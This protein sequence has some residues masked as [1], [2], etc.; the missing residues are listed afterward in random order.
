MLL[1][2]N[3]VT[4][5]SWQIGDFVVPKKTS[6][7]CPS[8]ELLSSN[9]NEAV[10]R[11]VFESPTSGSLSAR[12][13]VSGSVL[14]EFVSKK[15][16]DGASVQTGSSFMEKPFS[17]E[18][19]RVPTSR[20]IH[21]SACHG[22]KLKASSA[23]HEDLQL[24]VYTETKSMDV[25]GETKSLTCMAVDENVRADLKRMTYLDP[26]AV[27]RIIKECSKTSTSLTGLFEA[28][29]PK[30][31]ME[32]L[33]RASRNIQQSRSD[34]NLAQAISALGKLALLVAEKA[35]PDEC[36][37]TVSDNE[38]KG[39][40]LQSQDMRTEDSTV[41]TSR[42]LFQRARAGM[43]EADS[44][45]ALQESSRANRL[46]SLQQRRRMLLSMMSRARRTEGAS[47]ADI[48]S[49][50]VRGLSPL[51]MNADTAAAF[52]FASSGD[53]SNFGEFDEDQDS[54]FPAMRLENS[55]PSD[56]APYLAGSNSECR[57][58]EETLLDTVLRGRTPGMLPSVEEICPVPFL[59]IR[60]IVNL[61]ILSNS[62]PWLKALLD[63]VM[64]KLPAKQA[65]KR[66]S[67]ILKSA[68]DEDRTPLL[69]VAM[70]LGCSG[71]I[72]KELIAF[73]A[74]VG[75]SEIQI[76]AENDLPEALSILLNYKVYSEGMVD[77]QNCSSDVAAVVRDAV[78]RQAMQLL[79]LRKEADVFLVSFF[80][81]MLEIG[82]LHRRRQQHR[83]TELCGRAIAGTIIGNV[84]LCALHEIQTDG[85][86]ETGENAG[87]RDLAIHARGL[88]QTL[89]IRI[90]GRSLGEGPPSLTT[91]LL[92][93]EEFLCSKGINDG[94]CGLTLLVTLLQR[95]PSF[96]QSPEIERYG[97]A[98]LVASHDAL[99]LNRLSDISSRVAKKNSCNDGRPPII[100]DS[101]LVL[102]P[103]KHAAS[104]HITKHSSFRCDLCGKGVE[105]GAIMHGCRECDWDACEFCTDKAEGGIV[106]WK[107]VRELASKCQEL[108]SQATLTSKE[109]DLPK[110]ID[111]LAL[112]TQISEST[113]DAMD[114]N[115]LSIRLLQRDPDSLR[116]LASMLSNRGQLTMHQFLCVILPALHSALM[117]KSDGRRLELR[118]SGAGR[119][120][121]KPRVAGLAAHTGDERMRIIEEEKLYFAKET[122][123]SFVDDPSLGKD[124]IES[125]DLRHGTR[126]MNANADDDEYEGSDDGYDEQDANPDSKD[127]KMKDKQ[128]PELFR[129]L[130][131]VL[132][133]HENVATIGV[134][135]DGRMDA[136]PT[137]ELQSLTKPIRILLIPAT[138][139]QQRQD[140]LKNGA[141]TLQVEPLVSVED[142]SRQ[143]LKSAATTNRQYV[144]FCRNLAEDSSVIVEKAYVAK[145]Q[146]QNPWR[147]AKIVSF[148]EDGGWHTIRYACN[149][150]GGLADLNRVLLKGDED[151]GRIEYETRH[152]KLLLVAR[153]FVVIHREA[154]QNY[155]KSPFN[156]EQ[157]FTEGIVAEND[158]KLTGD[159]VVGH[160]IESDFQSSEWL[161]YTIVSLDCCNDEKKYALVSEDGEVVPGVPSNRIR[162]LGCFDETSLFDPSCVG[163]R[164]DRIGATGR[165]GT[166][167][168]PLSRAFPFL[169][170][171]QHGSRGEILGGSAGKTTNKL[172]LKRTWSALGP[173]ESMNPVGVK[174]TSD[175]R[176]IPN[177][178]FSTWIC[179]VGGKMAE[180][181]ILH[182]LVERPPS[183]VVQYSSTHVNSSVRLSAPAD[184]TVLSL[185]HS[186][187]DGEEFEVF[188]SKPHEI[189][190]SLDCFA[191]KDAK[192][193]DKICQGEIRPN[194]C[195]R[196]PVAYPMKT[197][198]ARRDDAFNVDEWPTENR[199]RKSVY[200]STDSDDGYTDTRLTFQGLD[201]ICVQCLE[202]IELIAE[203]KSKMSGSTKDDGKYRSI[204]V[205]E[206][207]SEKLSKQLENPLCVV[208]GAVPEW[209]FAIPSF[210]PNM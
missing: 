156:M 126:S 96:L 136:V 141:L 74:P 188:G 137:S 181:D 47:F 198:F 26:S 29:L 192:Y 69:H 8:Q 21:T 86:P 134:L 194:P 175:D 127:E 196:Q 63:S 16:A 72:I 132:S 46:S 85:V 123:K 45:A 190:Y 103:K 23:Q 64:K 1:V 207:L 5:S 27:E 138:S 121:K 105:R 84:E 106:K 112:G 50:D 66:E 153:T 53:V 208:G 152:T 116:I 58:S 67:P 128:L 120:S 125:K 42:N 164:S 76:A 209:C 68:T 155:L 201:E 48:L 60:N 88:M 160:R 183:L 113:D 65:S 174:A 81:K 78:S 187:C 169:T 165:N 77:L 173:I 4:S 130:H 147:I 9:R 151:I 89:P 71:V 37:A 149:L 145:S 170:T 90:L 99:A 108:L 186:L 94:G 17:L 189:I 22:M 178:N 193:M 34:E 167:R 185:L 52:L 61:G 49:R 44:D 97:F 54:H 92:L 25:E 109:N 114:A 91:L 115:T 210:A 36:A 148:D 38:D 202:I 73:G 199:S 158:E 55:R 124:Q 110:D 98:E 70:F 129:R 107:Y 157:L 119:R 20:L 104:L 13:R 171:R 191:S 184:T 10:G 144:A 166:L 159:S 35:F 41:H 131:Q 15:F 204:F 168:A 179:D 118:R 195:D 93:I 19:R 59:S 14:V 161:P 182:S 176:I 180:I 122:I 7:E 117:G 24:D 75:E 100:L 30:M 6:Q 11:I 2:G 172:V 111:W 177:P 87:S 150:A 143:L 40:E 205:N 12:G 162:G 206:M 43:S 18:S 57:L 33:D 203:V 62:L 163:S 154:H 83:E 197:A 102:C 133:L 200:P 146:G 139:V 3:Q 56:S 39:S 140:V 79:S 101:C 95:F 28:G 51:E 31:S 80:Q 82:L 142:I 135:N 32:A